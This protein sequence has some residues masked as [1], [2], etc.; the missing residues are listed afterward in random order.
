MSAAKIPKKLFVWE[1][2]LANYSSGMIV[3]LAPDLE[4]ALAIT[5]D[6]YMRADM[7]RVTPTVVDLSGK[8]E[9]Q[10]WYVHGG[11]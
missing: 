5:K 11:G 1:G 3:V 6:D 4:T 8:I 7:G 2:V 10:I 9:P